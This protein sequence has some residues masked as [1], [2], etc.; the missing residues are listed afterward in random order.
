M[1]VWDCGA[2]GVEVECGIFGIRVGASA[3]WAIYC[4]SISISVCDGVCG[5]FDFFI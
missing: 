5:L 1:V 4:I 3:R 2:V